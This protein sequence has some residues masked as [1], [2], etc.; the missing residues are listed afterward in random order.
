MINNNNTTSSFLSMKT[1]KNISF[2][3]KK[4]IFDYFVKTI[5]DINKIFHNSELR[6]ITQ[7]YEN[8]SIIEIL[9]VF[10]MNCEIIKTNMVEYKLDYESNFFSI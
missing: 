5:F 4:N 10:R 8:K 2:S 3:D 7:L 1:I 9:E 6:K